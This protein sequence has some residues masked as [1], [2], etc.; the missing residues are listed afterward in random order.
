[1]YEFSLKKADPELKALGIHT[2]DLRFNYGEVAEHLNNCKASGDEEG[3]YETMRWM[4]EQDL[5]F[6]CYFVLDLPVNDPFLIARI[7]EVQN[8]H[9]FTVDLW[10]REHFK[11]SVLSFGLTIWQ[12]IHNPE[13]RICLFSHTRVM[14]KNHLRRIKQTLEQNIILHKAFPDIFFANPAIASSM[15]LS[16]T[17]HTM[18]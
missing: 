7:Y 5:F 1:M 16:K 12:L 10:S 4:S 14:A 2:D 17:S 11:S 15:L 8:L 18:W 9:H 3:F 6:L 13:E